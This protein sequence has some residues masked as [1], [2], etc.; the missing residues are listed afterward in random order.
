MELFVDDTKVGHSAGH[1]NDLTEL[2]EDINKLVE[3]ANK[4]QMNV[5]VIMLINFHAV[6]HI[7]HNNIHGNYIA[8]PI[9]SCQQDNNRLTS[10]PRCHHHQISQIAETIREMRQNSKQS[11]IH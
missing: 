11:N 3:L 7:Y 1:T 6:T 4:R 10:R 2:Q 5:N 8:S 9:N